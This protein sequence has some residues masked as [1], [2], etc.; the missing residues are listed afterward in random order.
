MKKLLQF[1]FY[2]VYWF[3]EQR[4]PDKNPDVYATSYLTLWLFW[5][6]IFSVFLFYSVFNLEIFELQDKE[7]FILMVP[8]ILIAAIA[9]KKLIGN[10]GYKEWIKPELFKDT[11]YGGQWNDSLFWA[12]FI[13]PFILLILAVTLK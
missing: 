1:I 4:W 10:D 9:W 5:N 7:K 6:T 11:I 2:K 13:L 8:G 3:Y 12:L